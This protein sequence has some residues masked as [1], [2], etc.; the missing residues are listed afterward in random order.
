MGF[1]RNIDVPYRLAD[2]D[3][4]YASLKETGG[5]LLMTVGIKW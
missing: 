5:M 3:N 2:K 4:S 1:N